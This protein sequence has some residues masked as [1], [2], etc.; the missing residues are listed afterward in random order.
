MTAELDFWTDNTPK[1][2]YTMEQAQG[3]GIPERLHVCRLNTPSLTI[4]DHALFFH[5]GWTP[6]LL[7]ALRLS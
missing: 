5:S 3:A 2:S 6:F 1:K 7:T 4:K